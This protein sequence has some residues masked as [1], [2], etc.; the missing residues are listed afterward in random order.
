MDK[1]RAEIRY[2]NNVIGTIYDIHDIELKETESIHKTIV[3]NCELD[4]LHKDSS[5]VQILKISNQ[6]GVIFHNAYNADVKIYI[7]RNTVE[8]TLVRIYITDT[9]EKGIEPIEEYNLNNISIMAREM[10][11]YC[12]SDNRDCKN[13][14][15]QGTCKEIR[16][17]YYPTR[18]IS[19]ASIYDGSCMET[20]E[21]YIEV[22]QQTAKLEIQEINKMEI[23]ADCIAEELLHVCDKYNNCK[24]CTHYEGICDELRILMEIEDGYDSFNCISDNYGENN[25]KKQL[26]EDI[27]TILKN[28]KEKDKQI[29]KGVPHKKKEDKKE[30]KKEELRAEKLSHICYNEHLC[31]T[32]R[33][34][35]L[36][37]DLRVIHGPEFTTVSAT[38]DV[39]KVK[40][41]NYIDVVK[42]NNLI[43]LLKKVKD[44]SKFKLLDKTP[45]YT[46]EVIYAAQDLYHECQSIWENRN[47]CD[48]TECTKENL[49]KQLG[50]YT[51][52][53]SETIHHIYTGYDR[54][55]HENY[56]DRNKLMYD[57]QSMESG[58]DYYDN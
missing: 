51:G 36:C 19:I 57:M 10:V 11:E 12:K 4:E 29:N 48:C 5:K 56:F 25:N 53:S 49:C 38:F 35:E 32:C 54:E 1:M 44:E 21:R 26:V 16:D 40:N 15:F 8:E 24:D 47:N 14:K 52:E 23:Q 31:C 30:D 7:T 9:E 46:R 18:L 27:V 39:I 34:S 55:N 50:K 22:I 17:T 13:C 6:N 28:E 2:N 41:F 3:L 42:D 33:Y 45:L 58:V 20:I 43:D 37:D